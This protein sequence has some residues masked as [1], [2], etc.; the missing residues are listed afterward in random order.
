MTSWGLDADDAAG[1]FETTLARL[2][3]AYDGAVRIV[4][5]VRPEIVAAC[6]TRTE[7]LLKSR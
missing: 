7:N 2:A 1:V 3:D 5:E 6:K 4:P